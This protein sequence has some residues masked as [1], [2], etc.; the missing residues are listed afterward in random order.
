MD[1]LKNELNKEKVDEIKMLL[2]NYIVYKKVEAA[3]LALR[4]SFELVHGGAGI[5]ELRKE[6]LQQCL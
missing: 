6:L 3:I 1:K 4:Y 2:E 5:P